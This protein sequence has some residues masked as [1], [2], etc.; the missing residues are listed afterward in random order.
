MLLR[1]HARHLLRLAANRIPLLLALFLVCNSHPAFGADGACVSNGPSLTPQG[2]AELNSILN[3]G[4]LP[5]LQ[6]PTFQEYLIEVREFYESL[7]NHLAWVNGNQPTAQAR[8][9]VAKLKAAKLDGLNSDD[10]DASKWDERLARF[11]SASPVSEMDLV[12]FDVALTVSAMRYTSDLHNGR[13]NPRLYHF[14]FDF[15]HNRYDLSQFVCHKLVKAADVEKVF[16]EVEP[17]FPGYHRTVAALRTYLR[18][19]QEDSGA[20]LPAATNIVYP[21]ESYRGTQRLAQLLRLQGDT[22]QNAIVPSTPQTYSGVL[23]NGVKHFQARN[24]LQPDGRIGPETL[25]ALNIP[26]SQR[27]VQLQLALERWRWLPHQFETPPIVVNIPQFRLH[28]NDRAGRRI[29]SMKVVVGKAFEHETPIFFS[30][31]RS[32]TFLP[33]WNVP[34]NIAGAELVPEM[35]RDPNYLE[36]KGYEIVDSRGNVASDAAANDSTFDKI[37]S[38]EWLIRQKPGPA[39]AL[40]LVKF[41][42]PNPYGVY[43]HGTPA[44]ELFSQSRRDFSHGCIRLERPVELAAWLLRGNPEWTINKIWAAI[45]GTQTIRATLAQPVPILI[46]YATAV[47]SQDGEVHFSDDVYGYDAELEQALASRPD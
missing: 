1:I 35:E 43:L 17:P 47:V 15:N 30:Q 19:A 32:V 8:A 36:R 31:I 28:V 41:D 29:F 20:P 37:R 6:R 13:I 27:V 18:F 2:I 3:S 12:H 40:G 25:R 46:I 7:E 44:T 39:N 33:E 21:G 22:P 11:E 23:V 26:F 34:I 5:E 9:I 42:L 4:K 38:G 14:G 24:G 45:K 16:H 10:Y